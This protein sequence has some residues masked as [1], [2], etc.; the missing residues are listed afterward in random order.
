M[1]RNPDT[2]WVREFLGRLTRR[3]KYK[4]KVDLGEAG[5]EGGNGS[6]SC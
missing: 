4:M 6:G 1:I 2:V 5:C 3:C